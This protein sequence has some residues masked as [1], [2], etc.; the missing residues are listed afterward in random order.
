MNKINSFLIE[1]NH[2]FLLF[3]IVLLIFK[4]SPGYLIGSWVG[5]GI[6]L[7]IIFLTTC[8]SIWLLSQNKKT[9]SYK[10]DPVTIFTGLTAFSIIISVIFGSIF[11]PVYTSLTDMIELYR[12]FLYFSFYVIAKET[13][14][15]E[16][17]GIVKTGIIIIFIIEI[18]GVLQFYNIGNINYNIGLLY[19]TSDKLLMMITHQQ[20]IGS[21]FLNP[22]IYGSFI[23]I[24][25]SFLLSLLAYNY[26]VKSII[27]YPLLLLTIVS[28][29]F[30]TSR[31]AVITIFGLIVYWIIVSLLSRVDKLSSILRKSATVIGLFIIAAIILIPN[32]NYLNYAYNQIST[33]LNIDLSFLQ[34]DNQMD[35][36]D[37]SDDRNFRD[38]ITDS[39]ESVSSYKSRQ[40]YWDLN[41]N[42]FLAAPVFGSGPMKSEFVRFADNSYLYTL[43]RYGVFGLIVVAGFYLYLY[44]STA[45]SI[46]KNVQSPIGSK[47][48]TMTLHLS[49]MGYFVMAL[50][51]EV[52]YNIQTIAILY[53]IVGLLRNK[54]LQQSKETKN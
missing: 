38:S 47:V 46:K 40:Y 23:V 44:L 53:I 27:L 13:L 50:V 3:F 25:I 16:W 32:I 14:N 9:L 52:W 7:G 4:P 2:L 39:V 20:R 41:W 1:K 51:A 17:T 30:T 24:A 12:I 5:Q 42:Q 19:T 45:W 48:M 6:I 33:N 54:H 8:Y 11:F 15:L 43:A 18:F 31:T 49:V 22:N 37:E 26:R 29:F 21:T 34:N 35:E 36:N 10:K 28:V